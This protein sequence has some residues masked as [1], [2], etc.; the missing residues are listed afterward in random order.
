[1]K[2]ASVYDLEKLQ[3]NQKEL[4]ICVGDAQQ[5]EAWVYTL[6]EKAPFAKKITFERKE[7]KDNM[8]SWSTKMSGIMRKVNV[9]ALESLT[10]DSVNVYKMIKILSA[11]ENVQCKK[12]H[13]KFS[14]QNYVS[15]PRFRFMTPTFQPP[16][17]VLE[18][19]HPVDANVAGLILQ[20][21]GNNVCDL[22]VKSTQTNLSFINTV[23][24]RL[25]RLE[26]PFDVDFDPSRAPMLSHLVLMADISQ[27]KYA[28]VDEYLSKC[29]TL[30]DLRYDVIFCSDDGHTVV[31]MQATGMS[32]TANVCSHIYESHRAAFAAIQKHPKL[33]VNIKIEDRH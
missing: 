11:F 4:V 19:V 15:M 5:L 10:I 27:L 26:I 3:H 29:E 24:H 17:I 20:H 33:D 14:N 31:S 18:N 2:F 21:Y 32:V 28:N 12:L 8:A 1:M 16:R 30:P 22:I 7:Y 23:V 25:V 13:V 6:L 9:N